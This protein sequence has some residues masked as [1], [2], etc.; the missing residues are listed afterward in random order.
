MY[1]RMSSSR[2][3]LSWQEVMIS[4]IVLNALVFLRMSII[5]MMRVNIVSAMFRF[6]LCL[7]QRATTVGHFTAHRSVQAHKR[8]QGPFD[9][10]GSGTGVETSGICG[11][12]PQTIFQ[13]RASNDRW[14]S[15]QP[16]FYL[17]LI[18]V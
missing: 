7:C 1:T 17:P 12:C 10:P 18:T 5:G 13:T 9:Q 4:R 15:L 2:S 14:H 16:I 6:L 8:L 3:G 11:P